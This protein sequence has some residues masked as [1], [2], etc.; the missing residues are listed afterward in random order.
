MKYMV[1]QISKDRT[2]AELLGEFDAFKPASK[3]A[4]E[5]RSALEPAEGASVKVIHAND[6]LEG[7]RMVKEFRQPAWPVE[8][9]E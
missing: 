5:K 7:E 2:S 6:T 9:W 1:Y 4:K 8:E 3:F